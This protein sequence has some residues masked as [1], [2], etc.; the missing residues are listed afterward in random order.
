MYS[1]GTWFESR[2]GRT[3][4]NKVFLGLSQPRQKHTPTK[5][6]PPS[7]TSFQIH[8]TLITLLLTLLK[9]GVVKWNRNLFQFLTKYPAQHSFVSLRKLSWL[10]M[11][12]FCYLFEFWRQYCNIWGNKYCYVGFRFTEVYSLSNHRNWIIELLDSTA[13]C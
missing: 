5:P 9:Y 8:S 4:M 11:F 3:I 7:F 12:I 1:E 13:F 2:L 6:W 10:Y